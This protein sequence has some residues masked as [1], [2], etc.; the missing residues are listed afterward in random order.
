VRLQSVRWLTLVAGLALLAWLIVRSGP[1]RLAADLLRVGWWMIAL[2]AIAATRNFLRAGA[3]RLALGE[4]RSRFSMG[5]MY[6]L[7]MVS[8]AIQFAAVAGLLFGQTAKGWLL[9][10]RVSGPR[11]VSTVMID[12]LL[13]YL[14]AVVFAL[15]GIG[16]FLILYPPTPAARDA[17][18]GS[19]AV[20]AGAILLGW[21]AFR[22]RWIRAS[23]LVKLLGRWG[24]VRQKETV[25]QAADIDAQIF[26]FHQRHPASFR[27]ILALDFGCHFLSAFEVTVI[28]WVL[29]RGA[30]YPAG[31][32]V[33]AFTKFVSA[34]GLLVPGDLGIYQG[35]TGLIFLL[36]GYTL[37]T[38]VA[39]GLIRQIRS[40]LWA[41]F[42]FLMLLGPG[43]AR[44]E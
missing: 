6:S 15:G 43:Y 29:G 34:G 7:L 1:S 12:L 5:A 44:A 25:E 31:I 8:D 4:D 39:V 36:L 26:A 17:G 28:L 3:A 32:V 35:G 24:L 27:G 21:L 40:I 38:G 13:Y 19:A 9:A 23:S 42:G 18:L 2:L 16:L 30:H 11:A 14:S 37:A 10:R 20:L 41:G 22:R 33:E